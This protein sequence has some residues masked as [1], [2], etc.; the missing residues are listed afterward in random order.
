MSRPGLLCPLL[1]LLLAPPA[2]AAPEGGPAAAA[3][4]DQHDACRSGCALDWGASVRTRDRLGRCLAQCERVGLQCLDRALGRARGEDVKPVPQPK[5]VQP[6]QAPSRYAAP[7]PARRPRGSSSPPKGAPPPMNVGAPDWLDE[8][9]DTPTSTS[10]PARAATSAPAGETFR[11]S[12]APRAPEAA[13]PSPRSVGAPD[14]LDETPARVETPAA[15]TRA[16]SASRPP[17][18]HLPR[19]EAETLAPLPSTTDTFEPDPLVPEPLL[20]PATGRAA[21]ETLPP[22][23]PL[24][25]PDPLPATRQAPSAREESGSS[26]WPRRSPPAAPA[27]P[28]PPAKR[29]KPTIKKKDDISE[30]DP[31]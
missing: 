21:A 7:A 27:Q 12:A 31:D 4:E 20:P 25:P 10:P 14:W 19:A 1:L 30:W 13:P 11:P 18:I 24:A 26:L 8:A 28:A 17:A 16:A 6:R 5:N 9:P 15:S 22:L 23:E 29:G 3:C 2:S